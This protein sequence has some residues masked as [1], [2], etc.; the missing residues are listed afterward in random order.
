MPLVIEHF[1]FDGNEVGTT[2]CSILTIINPFIYA[3]TN[4]KY[5]AAY[6]K[7]FSDI[8]SWS[9]YGRFIGETGVK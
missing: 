8:K 7:L 9:F 5:R 6:G 3:A 4:R 2:F 1:W